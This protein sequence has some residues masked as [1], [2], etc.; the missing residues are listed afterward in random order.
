MAIP[1]KVNPWVKR[2][3]A[4]NVT[5]LFVYIG[6]IFINVCGS[7]DPIY[8]DW[9]GNYCVCIGMNMQLFWES[10]AETEKNLITEKMGI[11]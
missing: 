9:K 10:D 4:V 1:T 7:C 6:D 11:I 2:V 5:I 3:L 8:H